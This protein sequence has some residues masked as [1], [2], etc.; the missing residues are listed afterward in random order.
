MAKGKDSRQQRRAKARAE[1]KAAIKRSTSMPAVE[2][3]S[4]SG[5]F[6]PSIRQRIR[7]NFGIVAFLGVCASLIAIWQFAIPAFSAPDIQ[8]TGSDPESPFVFPFVV[9]NQSWAFGM[10]DIGLSCHVKHME[11]GPGITFDNVTV[12]FPNQASITPGGTHNYSC[13]V[14]NPGVP[15]KSLTMDVEVHFTNLFFWHRT[16]SKPFIWIVDGEQSRWIEGDLEN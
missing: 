3:R 11:A 2:V 14:M 10:E 5:E 13:R 15:I 9:K 6:Q 7:D 4:K 12:S 16:S 1:E 8:V